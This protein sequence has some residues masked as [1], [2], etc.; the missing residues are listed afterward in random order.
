VKVNLVHFESYAG[1]TENVGEYKQR[2][3]FLIW[4]FMIFNVFWVVVILWHV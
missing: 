3:L 1:R 2:E 4:N